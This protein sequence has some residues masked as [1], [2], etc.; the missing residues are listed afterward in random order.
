MYKDIYNTIS[1]FVKEVE[2]ETYLCS[3]CNNWNGKRGPKRRLLI[4]TV[5]A[6]NILKY[7]IH[8][9]DLKAFHRIIKAINLIPEIPNYENFLK[10]SNKAIPIMTLFLNALLVQNRKMNKTGIH[11]IDSTPVSKAQCNYTDSNNTDYSDTDLFLSC[12]EWSRNGKM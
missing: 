12:P 5:I 9:K 1:N 6:L 2:E 7:F 3:F 4:T 8:V 11:F 10:V